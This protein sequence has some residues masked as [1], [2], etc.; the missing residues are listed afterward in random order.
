MVIRG[1][2]IIFLTGRGFFIKS[3]SS[4]NFRFLLKWRHGFNFVGSRNEI[5]LIF[6]FS[7][8]NVF[9]LFF[10]NFFDII[11][12]IN[13]YWQITETKSKNWDITQRHLRQQN[14]KNI[15]ASSCYYQF[16]NRE[17]K[18]PF[19]IIIC[20]THFSN[21]TQSPLTEEKSNADLHLIETVLLWYTSVAMRWFENLNP[22]CKHFDEKLLSQ[23]FWLEMKK[24]WTHHFFNFSRSCIRYTVS[25]S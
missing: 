1:W 18:V 21:G 23:K 2:R 3:W 14:P 11:R 24:I 10:L 13:P 6:S 8:E 25:S 22:F 15:L 16:V 19:C 9:F 20:S 5:E 7:S 4:S 12:L 17:N